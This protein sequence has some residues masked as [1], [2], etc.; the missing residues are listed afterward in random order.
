MALVGLESTMENRL[1]IAVSII[2]LFL[3]VFYL[4]RMFFH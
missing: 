3:F 1:S 4:T 2:L